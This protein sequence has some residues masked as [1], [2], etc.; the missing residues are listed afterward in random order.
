MP[1]TFSGINI[2]RS[3][4]MAQ[5]LA[6]DIIGHNIANSTNEGYSRQVPL[7][8]STS[9]LGLPMSGARPQGLLG[10]GSMLKSV[11]RLRSEYVEVQIR[12]QLMDLSAW[13]VMSSTMERVSAIFNQGMVGISQAVENL[14]AAFGQFGRVVNADAVATAPINI[15]DTVFDVLSG[16][17]WK[18]ADKISVGGESFTIASVVGNTITVTSAAVAGHAVGASVNLNVSE[19]SARAAVKSQGDSLAYLLRQSY[20]QLDLVAME[21]NNQIKDYVGKANQ[22]VTEIA[23]LNRDIS[24]ASNVGVNPNDHLDARDEAMRQLGQII[25]YQAHYNRNGSVNIILGGHSLVNGGRAAELYAERSTATDGRYWQVTMRTIGSGREVGLS[26]YIDAGALGGFKQV[27]DGNVQYYI[28]KVNELARSL[29]NQVNIIHTASYAKDWLTTDVDFYVGMDA[30]DIN[31][32]EVISAD[33]NYALLCGSNNSVASANPI[34]AKNALLLEDLGQL[35][36]NKVKASRGPVNNLFVPP[37][38]NPF[39]PIGIESFLNVPNPLGG[40]VTID[41]VAINWTPA[42]TVEDILNRVNDNVPGVKMVFN[43]A[44]QRFYMLSPSYVDIADTAGNFLSWTDL[45]TRVASATMIGKR[46]DVTY[47]TV[48][49]TLALNDPNNLLAFAVTPAKGGSFTINGASV[50]WNEGQTMNQIM[51]LINFTVPFVTA[52]FNAARQE[53]RLISQRDIDI[54]DVTGNFTAFTNLYNVGRHSDFA[55]SISAESEYDG[56]I[57]V[58]QA[59]FLQGGLDTLVGQ[60]KAIGGVN[61]DVELAD[62]LKYEKA[63]NATVQVLSVLDSMLNTLINR[64]GG[65]GGSVNWGSGD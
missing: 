63:Y 57:S 41:G 12:S 23:R 1:G 32:N 28:N 6:L 3:S 9:P 8:T 43:Q 49:P 42:D 59:A 27:R 17:L 15:G 2:A 33:N 26:K 46:D 45:R 14:G 38:V 55:A 58:E 19:D 21:A 52:A 4:L 11:Y 34:N 47:L 56:I 35:L 44:E 40:T 16:S 20:Q 36:M 5:Q 39:N 50:S 29:M 13:Q 62:I 48:D 25:N 65:G 53:L 60:Q 30:R 7:I 31:I 51:A 37:P 54:G 24:H 61:V 22:I 18:A 64:M 10:T